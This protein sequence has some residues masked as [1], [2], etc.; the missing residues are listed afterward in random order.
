MPR[1]PIKKHQKEVWQF[2]LRSPVLQ[3][4][5]YVH[6]HLSFSNST[7]AHFHGIHFLLIGSPQDLGAIG[8]TQKF[9]DRLLNY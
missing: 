9:W 4:L 8:Q 5:H 2:V 3:G 6:W 1:R 7:N